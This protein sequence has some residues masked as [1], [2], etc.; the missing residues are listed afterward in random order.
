MGFGRSARV[1]A[2]SWQGSLNMRVPRPF[3]VEEQSAGGD[4]FLLAWRRRFRSSSA[5]AGSR[6]ELNCLAAADEIGDA[7]AARWLVHAEDVADEEVAAATR[8][9][10]NSS[11]AVPM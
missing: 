11:M 5:V 1:A 2:M 9:R 4:L 3:A 6:T 8:P 7:D 10:D